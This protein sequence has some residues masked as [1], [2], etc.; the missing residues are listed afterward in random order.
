MGLR[1]PVI[2]QSSVSAAGTATLSFTNAMA[3]GH[4][5]NNGD[6]TVY[7]KFDA[8]PGGTPADNQ[9]TLKSG[10]F[11]NGNDLVF[12]SV[13]FYGLALAQVEVIAYKAVEGVRIQ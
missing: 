9:F 11:Y 3:C 8:V 6:G 1:T 5:K 13:S 4:I 12:E 10:E 7:V 2:K